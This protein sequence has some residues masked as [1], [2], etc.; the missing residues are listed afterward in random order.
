MTW[1]LVSVQKSFKSFFIFECSNFWSAC[2][3]PP[4]SLKQNDKQQNSQQKL[5][6]FVSRFYRKST[7]Q[8]KLFVE[9]PT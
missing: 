2:K 4:P 9:S 7:T 3:S 6:G 5:S 1:M 8:N